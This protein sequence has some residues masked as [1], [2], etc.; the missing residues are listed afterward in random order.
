[1][2][3]LNVQQ[4]AAAYDFL[5]LKHRID[6]ILSFSEYWNLSGNTY[7]LLQI[8]DGFHDCFPFES[9][10]LFDVRSVPQ[11]PEFTIYVIIDRAIFFLYFVQDSL[12]LGGELWSQK[13]FDF[14]FKP[15]GIENRNE[16]VDYFKL[17]LYYDIR[18]SIDN[19][20]VQLIRI[21][22][23][24]PFEPKNNLGNTVDLRDFTDSLSFNLIVLY[25]Q[26]FN[27]RLYLVLHSLELKIDILDYQLVIMLRLTLQQVFKVAELIDKSLFEQYFNFSIICRRCVV[28]VPYIPITGGGTI[29]ILFG[30]VNCVGWFPILDV[31][32]SHFLLNRF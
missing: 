12:E 9:Y 27:Y 8:F 14:Y 13:V 24:K 15:L 4:N 30:R 22:S 26:I 6:L 3:L 2:I 28:C 29:K 5:L 18:I 20:F 19:K 7:R 23:P 10:S 16:S 1:M 31:K 21:I 17:G 25:Q 11:T 32:L